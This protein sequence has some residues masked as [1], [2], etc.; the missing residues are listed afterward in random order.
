[1]T[2]GEGEEGKKQKIGRYPMGPTK[3]KIAFERNET[4]V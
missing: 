4:L 1:M 3:M 2:E